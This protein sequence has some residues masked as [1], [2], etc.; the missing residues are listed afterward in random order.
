MKPSKR[1]F[2]RAE[3]IPRKGIT[4]G[5]LV[6]GLI[7]FA[8]ATY[9]TIEH[10]RG[11]DQTCGTFWDCASV[12]SSTYAEIGG[13]PTALLGTL[14]YLFI[15][16]LSVAYVDTR[17]V[18]LVHVIVP[19]TGI[20]FV[21]SLILVYLQVFVIHALCLYCMISALT[22]TGLLAVSVVHIRGGR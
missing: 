10:L 19:L 7:G 20:G 9:L 15:F 17:Q 16:L 13:I 8:D 18:R 4:I 3:T 1:S 6:L 22:S 14:Y 12:A 11:G 2:F 5:W 21:V